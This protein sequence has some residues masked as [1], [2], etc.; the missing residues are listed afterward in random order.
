[1]GFIYRGN[2]TDMRKAATNLTCNNDPGIT[3]KMAQLM[4]HSRNV[5]EN[6]YR[7]QGGDMGLSSAFTALQNMESHPRGYESV[8][9][10]NITISDADNHEHFHDSR[11]YLSNDDL[12]NDDLS[13]QRNLKS[14]TPDEFSSF[15]SFLKIDN[16]KNLSDQLKFMETLNSVLNFQSPIEITNSLPVNYCNFSS[17]GETIISL[18]S[19]PSSP[20]ALNIFP[21][22]SSFP[23]LLLHHLEELMYLVTLRLPH[24]LL[25]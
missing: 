23:I 4:G 6:I 11:S 13:Y 18:I 17:N 19:I 1:M 20:F 9:N 12:S 21:P 8:S 25:H 5:H 14:A 22:I 10:F 7:V 24:L 16:P 2:V 3:D 15:D